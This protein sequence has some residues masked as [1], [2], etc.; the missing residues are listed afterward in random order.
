MKTNPQNFESENAAKFSKLH[1]KGV[2]RQ[3][4]NENG[5]ERKKRA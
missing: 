2:E 4:R 3:S 1:E 5:A